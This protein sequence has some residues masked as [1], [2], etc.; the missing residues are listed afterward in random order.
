MIFYPEVYNHS[1]Y[2]SNKAKYYMQDYYQIQ[3]KLFH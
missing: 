3:L 1:T 2:S